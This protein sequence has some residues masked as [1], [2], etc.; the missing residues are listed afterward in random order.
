MLEVNDI[1][2]QYGNLRVLHGVSLRVDL[3]QIVSLVGG[4]GA[5]KTTLMNV[6][7]GLM[8]PSRGSI[9]LDKSDL[10]HVPAFRIVEKGL[11]QIPEG[12]KLFYKMCV[13]EN[14]L[15]GATHNRARKNVDKSLM[16]V[17]EMFPILEERKRQLARTLSGG[18]QQMLAIARA[19]M[20][21]P[22]LVL[23]DEPSLGLAP[24]IVKRI[25]GVI[26]NLN[27]KGLSIFLVEQDIKTSLKTSHYG[28]VLENG[29]IVLEGK[30]DSLL[31][32]EYTKKAYLGML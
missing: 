31:N 13:L 24:V 18:E 1:F 4:N 6:I 19:L 32:N 9:L 16:T 25:F 12:R 5:G 7:S 2:A 22:K 14:L 3:K 15:I 8:R 11:V 21:C 27:E 20:S 10:A 30:G 17:Y 26:R 29:R 28:Y 23:M